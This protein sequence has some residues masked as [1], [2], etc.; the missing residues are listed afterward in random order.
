MSNI[1]PD[2]TAANILLGLIAAEG[3]LLLWV[4]WR[5]VLLFGPQLLEFLEELNAKARA[6]TNAMDRDGE[7]RSVFV[8][9][10]PAGKNLPKKPR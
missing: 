4:I 10:G 3:A 1:L 9:M 6:I 7:G 2:G 5:G 8:V